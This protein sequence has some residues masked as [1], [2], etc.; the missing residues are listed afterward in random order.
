MTDPAPQPAHEQFRTRID[1]LFARDAPKAVILRRGPKRHFHLIAWDLKTDT[2]THG[3]WMKATGLRLCDLSP[4]GSKLIYWASQYH[5]SAPRH[6]HAARQYQS[7]TG[8]AGGPDYEPLLTALP[9]S[10]A[11]KRRKQPRY[12][13]QGPGARR[14]RVILRARRNEGVW[15]AISTLPFFSALAIWPCFGHWTGGGVF[16]DDT[17]IVLRELADGLVP[18]ANVPIPQRF[19]VLSL[20]SVEQ[21]G[22]T[23]QMSAYDPALQPDRQQKDLADHLRRAGAQR[24]EWVSP[25]GDGSLLFACDG[26]IYRL[27]EWK[28][29]DTEDLLSQATLIAD[30]RP[31]TFRMMPPPQSAMR[32]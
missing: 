22:R 18:Q 12:M 14:G 19:K 23:L 11:H 32:W 4:D 13:R 29:S 28:T 24:V 7:M 31:L 3:Q 30:L 15:T 27:K 25:H 16:L 1:V 26:R 6:V 10:R 20:T 9:R 17:R 21:M 5:T 8:D 2:L